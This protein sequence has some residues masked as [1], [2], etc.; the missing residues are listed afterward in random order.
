MLTKNLLSILIPCY[1]EESSLAALIDKVL[2]APLQREL[3][4]ELVIVDDA[5]KDRSLEVARAYEAAYPGFI[6]VVS[7]QVNQGKGAAIRTAIRHATGEFAVIQDADLEYD[8]NEIHLLMKPI[9][10]GHADVVYGSRFAPRGERRVLYFWHSVANNLLTL[11]C[12]MASNLNLTDMETCYKA[13][14]SELLKSIPIRSE[15]FGIEPEITIKVSKRRARV[16]EVPISYHGRTYAEGKKI[17]LKDA[18]DAV[19]VI[20]RF[21]VSNDIYTDSG[22]ETLEEFA[23]AP[24]FN[25][26]MADMI[27]PYVKNRVLEIGAGIGNLTSALLKD[28]PRWITADIHPDHLSK[29]HEK[30]RQSSNVEICRCDL[31]NPEDFSKL[32]GAVD[33]VVCLN[34]LEHVQDDLIGLRNIHSALSPGG[35]A[36]VLVPHGQDIYGTMD[37]ALGHFRR[38]SQEELK[39][40]MRQ[41]GFEVEELLEFNRVSRPA[42]YFSGRVMKRR[43]PGSGP[44]KLFDHLV[45][46]FRRVDPILPWAPT[47]IIAVGRKPA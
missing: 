22:P 37:E 30:F 9:L 16:Y 15:R 41:A 26:W 6:R 3:D 44:L 11:L 36:V 35:R 28:H 43:S 18:F 25:A 45:W 1:N 31:T 27:R 19:W 23:N 8:P 7:H 24:K 32:A 47:S 46:L 5:S 17:G 14:R 12:N 29:L 39:E 13:F 34:V 20:A 2:A 4:R 40:K 42:W 21:A 38:Y 33:S 10:E